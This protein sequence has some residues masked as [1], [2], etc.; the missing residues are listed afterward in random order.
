MKFSAIK[1][2]TIVHYQQV[3]ILILYAV[4]AL[5]FHFTIE[6][7]HNGTSLV[8][9]LYTALCLCQPM[10]WP[11]QLRAHHYLVVHVFKGYW[12]HNLFFE[13]CSNCVSNAGNKLTL[14]MIWFIVIDPS[15]VRISV[16]KSLKKFECLI[17]IDNDRNHEYCLVRSGKSIQSHDK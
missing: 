13:I 7:A 2:Y 6:L 1:L 17:N 4:G 9:L 15:V 16:N 3:F 14:W 5:W 11:A 10:R 12:Q 8:P